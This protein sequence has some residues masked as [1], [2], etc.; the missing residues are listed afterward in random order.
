MDIMDIMDMVTATVG[1]MDTF[2]ENKSLKIFE[3]KDTSLPSI[4]T[5]N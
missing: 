2:M 1:T 5:E 4:Q 3:L